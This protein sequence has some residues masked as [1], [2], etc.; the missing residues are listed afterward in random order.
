MTNGERSEVKF[1]FTWHGME[2]VSWD[3]GEQSI[4]FAATTVS[5]L[6]SRLILA[7][8]TTPAAA[9]PTTLTRVEVCEFTAYSDLSD[10]SPRKKNP[11]EFCGRQ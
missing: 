7:V 1:D 4:V 6:S 10:L 3:A 8:L 2:P 11:S 5:S 9:S